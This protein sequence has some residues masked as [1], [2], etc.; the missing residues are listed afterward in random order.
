MNYDKHT[1]VNRIEDKFN[2]HLKKRV[3]KEFQFYYE[4]EGKVILRTTV[5][6][7]RGD[8]SPGTLSRIKN[9]LC[10]DRDFFDGFY[11]CHKKAKDYEKLLRE[12]FG[13]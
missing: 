11:D 3:G 13:L 9:Q 8:I 4:L 2:N 1:L 10:M 12:K 7:G 6:K 5:P